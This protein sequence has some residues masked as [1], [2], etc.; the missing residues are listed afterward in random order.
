MENAALLRVLGHKLVQQRR[1]DLAVGVFE[2]VL[3]LRA[4]EPQSYR[5]LALALARRAFELSCT[6]I[7]S[8]DSIPEKAAAAPEPAPAKRPRNVKHMS[9]QD[10]RAIYA[11]I[12]A[13]NICAIELLYKVVTGKWDGRFEEIEAIALT[14][15]NRILKRVKPEQIAHLKIDKAL[16]DLLDVDVRIVM[17]WDAD[18]TDIDLHVVEPSGEEV[19]YEHELSTIG[20]AISEDLTQGY[21]PEEYMVRKAAHGVYTIKAKYYGSGSVKITGAVTVQ[22]DI[23]TNFGRNDEDRKS[24]TV[25]LKDAKEMI[26]IGQ[27]EF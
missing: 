11:R 1:F 23:Y 13:D 8:R 4:E 21:G 6:Q 10:A 12:D 2:Q 22:V 26:T 15:M 20:G 9:I 14:E 16:K 27:I 19:S 3:K 7:L 25:Q 24:I 17:T 5:D 18:N